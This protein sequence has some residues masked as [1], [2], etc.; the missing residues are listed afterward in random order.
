MTRLLP[1]RK[2]AR[3]FPG[4]G[5]RNFKRWAAE[6]FDPLPSYRL[7]RGLYFDPDEFM[8]WFRRYE[9]RRK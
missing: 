9:Q 4:V 2:M 7:G 3:E 5:E 6:P 1:A 8:P